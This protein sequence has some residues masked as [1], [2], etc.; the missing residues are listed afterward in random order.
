ML[1][2]IFSNMILISDMDD[3]LLMPDKSVSPENLGALKE[4]R[5]LGGKFTVATGRSIPSYMRYHSLLKP[6][7]PVIL[8][9]GAVIYD[10]NSSTILWNTVLPKS[11]AAYVQDTISHFPDVG[12]EILTPQKMYVANMTPVI[13]GHISREHL[14]FEKA[15]WDTVPFPW[16]KVLFGAEEDR[17]GA[18]GQYL[19]EQ[20][21]PDVQYIYSSKRYCEMLPI[22][23]SK[24]SA[25]RQLIAMKGKQ[26]C[27]ICG[28]GDFYNDLELIAFADLGIAVGNAP[29]DV[30]AQ[31]DVVVCDNRSH[32][33]VEVV[34]Y[35]KSYA[36]ALKK[37]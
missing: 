34:E 8:N 13:Q 33:M 16:F 32:A 28:M 18:L 26:N 3:T 36:G 1:P 9:N 4:F 10:P 21:H 25:M 7:L 6:D 2:E 35:L 29:S 17:L 22:G 30:Q 37:S 12:A 19:K 24:G 27:I 31:A 15:S 14:C 5:R 20:N 23:S 11:A